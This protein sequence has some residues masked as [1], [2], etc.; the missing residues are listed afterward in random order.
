MGL[1]ER[2]SR[3]MT[4]NLNHMLDQAEDPEVMIAQ[5]I[6]DMDEAVVELR[7][8]TV[9]AVAHEK[10]LEK[11]LATAGV[12]AEKVEREARLALDSGDERLAR[13]IVAHRIQTLKSRDGLEADLETARSAAARLREDLH[14]V[15]Q[16]AGSARGQRDALV[17]RRRAAEA[18]LRTQDLARCSTLALGAGDG[19]GLAG[20]GA[21]DGYAEVVSEIEAR[22]DAARE[23]AA[24]EDAPQRTLDRLAEDAAID[25]ELARLKAATA[26][27]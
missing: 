22:A 15:Q 11:Q 24:A 1:M 23:L 17:R 26:G 4:A 13:Q 12:L 6:R 18:R 16:R 10:Q 14:Q 2:V 25:E 21:L 3:L 5:V 19:S 8:E 9:A 7:R 27:H 20:P